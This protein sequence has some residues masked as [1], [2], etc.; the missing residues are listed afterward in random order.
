MSEH[1]ARVIT[2]TT[3]MMLSRLIGKL[4]ELGAGKKRL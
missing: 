3:T 4:I 1:P 2:V